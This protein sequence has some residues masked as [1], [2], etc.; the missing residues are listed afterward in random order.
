GHAGGIPFRQ[1]RAQQCLAD[2]ATAVVGMRREQAQ[3]R[4]RLVMRVV[5]LEPL[6]QLLELPGS[7]RPEGM[8]GEG[9]EREE[10]VVIELDPTRRD[11]DGH[12]RTVVEQVDATLSLCRCDKEP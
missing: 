1:V 3:V 6:E 10:S 8:L 9:S 11:P 5:R 12:R 4:M 7:R 2:A